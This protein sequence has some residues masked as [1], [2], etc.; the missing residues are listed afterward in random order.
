MEIE[1]PRRRGSTPASAKVGAI[2]E[3]EST[4]EESGIRSPS[5]E[6]LPTRTSSRGH[7]KSETPIASKTRCKRN[8]LDWNCL[9]SFLYPVAGRVFHFDTDKSKKD[10]HNST[11]V[12]KVSRSKKIQK[13]EID[14]KPA[15]RPKGHSLIRKSKGNRP[16]HSKKDSDAV[17]I[18]NWV[19][20]DNCMKWRKITKST[21]YH[22]NVYL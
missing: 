12:P 5:A 2:L 6:N 21:F 13:R 4:E 9:A 15:L 14:S 1:K 22:I 3:G 18:E 7:K 20:C 10:Q 19:Q 11:V 17:L 8:L 16:T